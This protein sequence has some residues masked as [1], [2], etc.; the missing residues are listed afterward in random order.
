MPYEHK[1]P[2]HNARIDWVGFNECLHGLIGPNARYRNFRMVADI[3]KALPTAIR[4]IMTTLL[5]QYSGDEYL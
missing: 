2:W 3:L 1:A 5:S 4:I